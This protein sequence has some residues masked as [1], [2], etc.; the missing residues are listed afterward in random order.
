VLAKHFRAIAS[1]YFLLSSRFSSATRNK[2]EK[3]NTKPSEK[4]QQKKER[5]IAEAKKGTDHTPSRLY[6][7][8]RHNIVCTVCADKIN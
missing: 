7:P 3:L 8:H 1:L 6:N 2:H 4:A 5:I